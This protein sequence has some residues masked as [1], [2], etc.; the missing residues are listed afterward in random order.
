[1]DNF[2]NFLEPTYIK[3][4]GENLPDFEYEGTLSMFGMY[5]DTLGK[6]PVKIVVSYVKDIEHKCMR[7]HLYADGKRI[8]GVRHNFGK[9]ILEC[10]HYLATSYYTDYYL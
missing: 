6:P 7:F 5:K 3:H 1:L 10:A 4:N 8:R 9:P 2:V